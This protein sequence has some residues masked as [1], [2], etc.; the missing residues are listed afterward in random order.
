MFEDN[1]PRYTSATFASL[2]PEFLMTIS[3]LSLPSL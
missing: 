2:V 3:I 1:V